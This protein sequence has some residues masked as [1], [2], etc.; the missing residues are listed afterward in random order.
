MRAAV[1]L[2]SFAAVAAGVAAA[3]PPARPQHPPRDYWGQILEVDLPSPECAEALRLAN[4]ITSPACFIPFG[5]FVTRSRVD[6]FCTAGHYEVCYQAFVDTFAGLATVCPVGALP[7][8]ERHV[9]DRWIA[10]SGYLMDTY[11]NAC[12][13]YHDDASRSRQY[14]A[15]YKDRYLR[16]RRMHFAQ[17]TRRGLDVFKRTAFSKDDLI[18]DNKEMLYLCDVFGPG[19]TAPVTELDDATLFD[20]E[21]LRTMRRLKS[22]VDADA[23][24]NPGWQYVIDDMFADRMIFGL[25]ELAGSRGSADAP[26]AG[27]A[28]YVGATQPAAHVPPQPAAHP[29][30]SAVN[31]VVK[32]LI[33]TPV[34]ALSSASAVDDMIANLLE[35]QAGEDAR[36][37][38]IRDLMSQAAKSRNNGKSADLYPISDV[39][40]SFPPLEGDVSEEI[41][42]EI[43]RDIERDMIDSVV[44]DQSKQELN[45]RLR[46]RYGF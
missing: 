1:V 33:D 28:S 37:D 44:V 39:D 36:R 22:N 24:S 38:L 2:S 20:K 41:A 30:D 15:V 11:R 17:Q 19:E 8:G 6:K 21:Y 9:E 4:E 23:V 12:E 26:A 7:F 32:N 25:P 35:T 29:L 45:Y 34:A 14:C 3:G 40:Q 43:A 31:D 27:D 46:R 16:D 13:T 5:F 10:H 42:A 18:F